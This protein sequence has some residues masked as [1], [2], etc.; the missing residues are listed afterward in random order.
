[1]SRLAKPMQHQEDL[2]DRPVG[3]SFLKP[4]MLLSCCR[5][6]RAAACTRCRTYAMYGDIIGDSIQ[7]CTLLQKPALTHCCD[8]ATVV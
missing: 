7:A 5:S 8:S 2:E 4:M 6:H 3:P 1:M